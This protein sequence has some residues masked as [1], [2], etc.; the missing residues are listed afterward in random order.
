MLMN[1]SLGDINYNSPFYSQ[2]IGGN[3]KYETSVAFFVIDEVATGAT[4][5]GKYEIPIFSKVISTKPSPKMMFLSKKISKVQ[6]A[7][8]FL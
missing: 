4:N 2:I 3:A 6:R 1:L 5:K 7:V 8:S